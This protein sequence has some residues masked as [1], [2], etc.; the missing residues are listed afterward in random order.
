MK[1]IDW[2]L[3][4]PVL[5]LLSI[6][7]LILRSTTLDVFWVQMSFVGVG[8]VIWLIVSNIDHKIFMAFWAWGFI[9]SIVLLILPIVFGNYVR[10]SYRWISLGPVLV[11]TSEIVKPILLIFVA[12]GL[13][14]WYAWLVLFPLFMIWRQPDL[15]SMLV[16]LSGVF[17]MFVSRYSF[18]K[19]LPWVFGSLLIVGLTAQLFLHGYQK[20]RLTSFFNPY[21][22]PLNNGYHVI[23]SVI[24]V[25]SG[26]IWGRGL[27]RGTQSQLRFLPEHHTDF[28]FATTAEELGFAGSILILILYFVILW[29]IYILSKLATNQPDILFLQ[30]VLG[31][32]T[33]QIFVNIG[34]NIGLAPVTGITLPFLSYGGS[35]IVALMITFGI[36]QSISSQIGNKQV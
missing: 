29:R 34:M 16:L 3:I 30:G 10:G 13:R 20:E 12:M 35:S 27:G 24:A 7:L 22:D 5:F 18:K 1:R 11:Q 2:W 8:I 15:G 4:L 25:G 36:L 31:M 21:S 26:G 28:I 17:F 33:F 6:S 14:K 32:L 23:Q 9:L 19:V